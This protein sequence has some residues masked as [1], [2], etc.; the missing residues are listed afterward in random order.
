MIINLGG[1]VVYK[2]SVIIPAYNSQEYIKEAIESV[3]NQTLK[4]IEIILVDDGS[5]DDTFKVC[6]DYSLIDERIKVIHQKNK[7]ISGARNTG[8][9][10]ATGEYISFLDS[11]DTIEL[12]MY[13]ELYNCVT[14]YGEDKIDFIDCGINMINSHLNTKNSIMHGHRKKIKYDKKY[15]LEEVIPSMVNISNDKDKF[16]FPFVWNRLFKASIIKNNNIRFNEELRQWEDR[17][18]LVQF[19]HEINSATFYDK[20]FY[21]YISGGDFSLSKKYNHNEFKT[22]LYTFNLY[23]ELFGDIYD[24]N[25]EYAI[26]Y[27]IKTISNTINKIIHSNEEKKKN[28]KILEMLSNENVIEWYNNISNMDLFHKMIRFCIVKKHFYLAIYLYKIKFSRI[29]VNLGKYREQIHNL[30]EKN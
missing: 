5:T 22:I 21:N 23:E 11:D 25:Q 26:K 12:N 17:P 1:K 27:K 13:E 2:V 9:D 24:F 14:Q 8:I 20:C 6:K 10:N 4:D 3:R 18:F 19:L 15:L 29:V 7:G 28:N 16:I 30:M